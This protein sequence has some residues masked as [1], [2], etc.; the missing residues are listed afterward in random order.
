MVNRKRSKC[1]DLVCKRKKMLHCF[2]FYIVYL[3]REILSAILD[4][5][6]IRTRI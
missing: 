2:L 1:S 5:A 3:K 4:D 6:S